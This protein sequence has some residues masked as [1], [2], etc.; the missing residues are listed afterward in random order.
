[1]VELKRSSPK[2]RPNFLRAENFAEKLLWR[3]ALISV[4]GTPELG[5][6]CFFSYTLS[7]SDGQMVIDKKRM[8]TTGSRHTAT[9]RM[10]VNQ[11]YG[12]LRAFEAVPGKRTE[13]D[14]QWSFHPREGR[15]WLIFHSPQMDSLW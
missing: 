13:N 11:I 10:M 4:R 9:V 12:C 6:V 15:A 7:L 3:K 1:M 2:S 14:S 8:A 5:E